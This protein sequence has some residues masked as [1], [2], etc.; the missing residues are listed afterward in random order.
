MLAITVRP[1]PIVTRIIIPTATEV[2]TTPI[3]MGVRTITLGREVRLILPRVVDRLVNLPVHP[4]GR[5][6]V[7]SRFLEMGLNVV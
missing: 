1:L 5:S 6:E 3:R 2:T 7:F 4:A